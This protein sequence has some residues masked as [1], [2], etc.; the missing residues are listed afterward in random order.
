MRASKFCYCI[1]FSHG[2]APVA[3]YPGDFP[4]F[5]EKKKLQMTTDSISGPVDFDHNI[6]SPICALKTQLFEH[7]P[8]AV[9]GK[10]T[11]LCGQKAAFE[12][13]P[14]DPASVCVERA[15][16]KDGG[17]DGS[18]WCAPGNAFSEASSLFELPVDYFSASENSH[19][20]VSKFCNLLDLCSSAEIESWSNPALAEALNK[21]G[22]L[23]GG[24]GS[25]AGVVVAIV[26]VLV[27]MVGFYFVSTQLRR[28]Q[29]ALETQ[30][31]WTMYETSI[32]VLNMF[33]DTPELRPYFY[34]GK[35]LEA[36]AESDEEKR[37]C[38]RQKVL[39]A[40]EI[41]GDHLENIVSSGENGSIDVGTYYVWVKYMRLMGLR[42]PVL[43]DFLAGAPDDGT[44]G[45]LGE[46]VRYGKTFR[47]I[48]RR[49]VVPDICLHEFANDPERDVFRSR[50]FV[51]AK[52]WDTQSCFWSEESQAEAGRLREMSARHCFRRYALKWLLRQE[53]GQDL[54]MSS[55]K[56]AASMFLIVPRAF[57][58]LVY[59]LAV[60]PLWKLHKWLHEKF[61]DLA[62][63]LGIAFAQL[64]TVG[65]IW[66]AGSQL[67]WKWGVGISLSLLLAYL[68]AVAV[69]AE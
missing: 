55:R 53:I 10:E 48:V 2:L 33:V 28:E 25:A 19:T 31:S 8:S 42:S 54:G 34:D 60:A 24:V 29:R 23:L 15:L 47:D 12:F 1:R 39:A 4:G 17:A 13:P 16:L 49:G 5:G 59:L 7:L 64:L 44:S 46:G 22:A 68:S 20:W 26:G 61:G 9:S 35:K 45:P 27:T 66:L 43:F 62:G 11:L 50:E 37:M 3:R 32:G 6:Y 67:G 41:V 63:L 51:H 58:A 18:V 65:A 21:L 38:E 14:R 40:A 69:D 36:I 56:F 52:A 30:T 57:A